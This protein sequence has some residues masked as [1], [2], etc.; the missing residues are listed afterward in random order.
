M[1]STQQYEYN[2]YTV[3]I[4][5]KGNVMKVFLRTNKWLHCFSFSNPMCSTENI[6]PQK[7]RVTPLFK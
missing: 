1:L 2:I 7:D 5:S 6:I 3:H 4:F